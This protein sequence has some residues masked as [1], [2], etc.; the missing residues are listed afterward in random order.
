MGPR[1]G[2]CEGCFRTLD[3]IRDWST[4]TDATKQHVWAA[5]ARRI[6]ETHPQEFSA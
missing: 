5:I 6:V 4:S 1:T 3:E 2:L